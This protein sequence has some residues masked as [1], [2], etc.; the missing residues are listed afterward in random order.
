MDLT[1]R[2][3][4]SKPRV[5]LGKGISLAGK[6]L[7]E[8]AKAQPEGR[9]RRPKILQTPGT[10]YLRRQYD[11]SKLKHPGMRGKSLGGF[12]GGLKGSRRK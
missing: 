1:G 11:I 2:K 10:S 3:T 9:G 5:I 8:L 7:G 6:G 4:P 12:G